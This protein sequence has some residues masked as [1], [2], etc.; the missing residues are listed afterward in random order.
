M[1]EN[2][3]IFSE[4]IKV[5]MR[6]PTKGDS[7]SCLLTNLLI[8]HLLHEFFRL[9]NIDRAGDGSLTNN[10]CARGR[11]WLPNLQ[12]SQLLKAAEGITL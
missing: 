12:S 2:I 8:S 6:S 7:N 11:I 1:F 4:Q 10:I 9:I 3:V 5:F